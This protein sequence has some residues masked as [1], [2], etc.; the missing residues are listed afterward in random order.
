MGLEYGHGGQ[1]TRTHGD[2]GELV[3]TAVSVDGEEMAACGVD[4]GY[5]EVGTDVTL[6]AEQMLLEHGHDSGD[7]RLA[8]GGEGV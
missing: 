7:A 6:V 4:A 1:R 3:G 8:A 2:V 5:D